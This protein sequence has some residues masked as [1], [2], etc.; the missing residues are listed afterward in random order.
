MDA[1]PKLR[2]EVYTN[3]RLP[4]QFQET[5]SPSFKSCGSFPVMVDVKV[6]LGLV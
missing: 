3:S 6:M 5:L 1:D 2:L 4:P